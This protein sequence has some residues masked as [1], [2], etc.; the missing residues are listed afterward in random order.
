MT[1]ISDTAMDTPVPGCSSSPS[2]WPPRLRL[3]T[4]P[5]GT[6]ILSGSAFPAALIFCLL[7]QVR[8]VRYR[9]GTVRRAAG[10]V[11][12]LDLT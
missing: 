3:T 10:V 12:P 5:G 9:H 1:C 7:A 6:A 8:L 11:N 4:V 2:S